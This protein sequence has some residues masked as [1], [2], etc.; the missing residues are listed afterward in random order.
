MLDFSFMDLLFT[1]LNSPSEVYIPDDVQC[2]L[3]LRLVDGKSTQASVLDG[4]EANTDKDINIAT[5]SKKETQQGDITYMPHQEQ[6][7]RNNQLLLFHATTHLYQGLT[8]LT[9][10]LHMFHHLAWV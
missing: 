6:T 8:N 9:H 1:D 4:E 5:C 3:S 2:E 10:L 7:I